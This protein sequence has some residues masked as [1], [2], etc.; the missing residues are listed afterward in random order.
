M[1]YKLQGY[2]LEACSCNAICPCWVGEDPD[3]GSCYGTIAWQ[4]EK[5]TI[6]GVDVSGLTYAILLYIANNAL[7]GNWRVV[8]CIDAKASE[9]QAEAIKSVFTGEQGG[10]V[11]DIAALIGEIVAVERPPITFDVTEGKGELTIGERLKAEFSP[12]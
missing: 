3:G 10:A 6:D 5:G 2:M 11:A 7:A 12:C 4:I 8:A 9:E 1:G